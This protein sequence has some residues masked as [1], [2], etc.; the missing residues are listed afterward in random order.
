MHLILVMPPMWEHRGR[1]ESNNYP[2]EGRK[3]NGHISE[4]ARSSLLA[5][6]F[7]INLHM[8]TDG[9]PWGGCSAK[10]L[11]RV[12]F[13]ST[14]FCY[15]AGKLWLLMLPVTVIVFDTQNR[16]LKAWPCTI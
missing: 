1:Q 8:K 2:W 3:R 10:T 15:Y 6:K 16:S 9:E 13:R 14:V 11:C 12:I 5:K 4:I 7:V